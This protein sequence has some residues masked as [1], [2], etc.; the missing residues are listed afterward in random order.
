M[1]FE[2]S[3]EIEGEDR[4]QGKE[5]GRRMMMRNNDERQMSSRWDR[6]KGDGAIQVQYDLGLMAGWLA[7]GCCWLV[8][9]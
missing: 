7:A 1:R 5:G 8:R 3:D 4:D 2:P 6:V 9:W